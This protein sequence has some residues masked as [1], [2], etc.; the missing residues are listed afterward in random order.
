MEPDSRSRLGGCQL[1]GR[2]GRAKHINV[3]RRDRP[4]CTGTDRVDAVQDAAARAF[5]GSRAGRAQRGVVGAAGAVNQP[6]SGVNV[7]DA[8]RG[9]RVRRVGGVQG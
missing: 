1:V 8:Q 2:G 6:R 4:R 7:A 5:D 3:V 9:K